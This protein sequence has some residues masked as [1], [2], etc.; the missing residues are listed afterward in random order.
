MTLETCARTTAR[1]SLTLRADA[2][3]WL[4]RHVWRRNSRVTD[5][6]CDCPRLR[7]LSV[8]WCVSRLVSVISATRLTVFTINKQDLLRRAPKLSF[9]SNQVCSETQR[10]ADLLP[11]QRAELLDSVDRKSK[12]LHRYAA[13]LQRC[14]RCFVWQATRLHACCAVLCRQAGNPVYLHNPKGFSSFVDAKIYGKLGS[15]IAVCWSLLI[16]MCTAVELG[17][18]AASKVAPGFGLLQLSFTRCDFN[19]RGVCGRGRRG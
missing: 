14:V 19:K 10:F 2:Q 4:W 16:R 6:V 1:G 5:A 18:S 11:G 13:I 15:H 17:Y 12:L 9:L 7:V 3:T 8:L